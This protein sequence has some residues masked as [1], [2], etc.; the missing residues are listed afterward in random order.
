MPNLTYKFIIHH[1]IIESSGT[2]MM[3][4]LNLLDVQW[5]S[6]ISKKHFWKKEM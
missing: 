1:N 2:T 3:Q 5:I 6:L 4:I